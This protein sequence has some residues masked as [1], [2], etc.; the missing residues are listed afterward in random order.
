MSL[1][2]DV[3]NDRI[4]GHSLD[5]IAQNRYLGTPDAV[6]AELA[7]KLSEKDLQSLEEAIQIELA[8]LD[9]LLRIFWTDAASGNAKAAQTINSLIATRCK[10]LSM[11]QTIP[12][13]NEENDSVTKD[14][15]T[16]IQEFDVFLKYREEF[17]EWLA[18]SV[19]HWKQLELLSA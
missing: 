14:A 1:P 9:E 2:E 8:R 12:V 11:I 19:P 17:F 15:N 4:Q 16:L 3:F 13:Q 6:R 7:K 10:V 5:Q 18:G